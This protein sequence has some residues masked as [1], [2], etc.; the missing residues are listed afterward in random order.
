LLYGPDRCC[1]YRA[2]LRLIM[3]ITSGGC[4]AHVVSVCC[5][6]MK[7]RHQWRLEQHWQYVGQ[8]CVNV[9]VLHVV[10][11]VVVKIIQWWLDCSDSDCVTLQ[12]VPYKV[13]GNEYI[14]VLHFCS[15]KS[16]IWP[17]P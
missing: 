5:L 11:P 10:A 16:D 14:I 8:W 17:M 7:P 2:A 4:A 3:G 6:A 1:L 12:V 13:L 15:I 9:L